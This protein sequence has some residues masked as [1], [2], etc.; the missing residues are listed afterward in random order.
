M[1]FMFVEGRAHARLI[2][3]CCCGARSLVLC[4]GFS[5][6]AQMTMV[7][8]KNSCDEVSRALVSAAEGMTSFDDCNGGNK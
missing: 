2:S 6:C 7:F 8:P 3:S 4:L 5:T 1:H